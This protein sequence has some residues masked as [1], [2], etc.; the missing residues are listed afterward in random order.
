MGLGYSYTPS[1]CFETF[2]VPMQMLEEEPIFNDG[3]SPALAN[4]AQKLYKLRDAILR[5]RSIGLT[6]LYGLFHD[7]S[8]QDSDIELLRNMHSSLD[9]DVIRCYGWDD[10]TGD[11]GFYLDFDALDE[12]PESIDPGEM[13]AKVF[14]S[15]TEAR[16]EPCIEEHILHLKWLYGPDFQT[17][18]KVLERLLSLNQKLSSRHFSPEK[19]SNSRKVY[20]QESS[21]A[22]SK[23]DQGS[24][25]D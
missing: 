20:N 12:I 9:H 8:V 14:K 4:T 23:S 19:I 25:F 11:Q 10:L 5:D 22:D 1:D 24:L 7:P 6:S 16:K 2:P 18:A 13:E 17:R 15:L 21:N 3:I